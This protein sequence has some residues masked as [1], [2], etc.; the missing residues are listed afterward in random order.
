MSYRLKPPEPF[1][2]FLDR[3]L[4]KKKIAS[5]LRQAGI[6]VHV[7]DDYFSPDARDEEWLKETGRRGWVVFT[8]DHRIRYRSPELAAIIRTNVRAFVL[9]GGNLQGDEMGRIFVKA[10]PAIRRFLSKNSPPFVATVTR[11]GS[12]SM[13]FAP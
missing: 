2:V 10:L 11:G 7:H 13:V 4:G 6:E 5:A 9:T 1:I 8:K 3:S 12:V